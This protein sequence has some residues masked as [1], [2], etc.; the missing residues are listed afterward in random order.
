MEETIELRAVI[1][2]IFQGKLV[3]TA[4]TI[5]TMLLA[6]IVSWFV[7][8]E[9]YES[10]ATVQ[11]ISNT[12]ET[13]EVDILLNFVTAEFTPQVFMQRIKNENI[14]NKAFKEKSLENKYISKHL[15]A[16]NAPNTAIVEL[17]YTSN[18]AENAQKEL[19]VI[20]ESTK[21]Q[22][23]TSIQNTLQNLEKTYK[24]ETEA[25]GTE[26]EQ[27]INA[28]NTLIRANRLPNILILQTILSS[29]ITLNITEEQTKALAGVNG[30]MQHQLLQL[31]AQIQ[32]KSE[33]YRKLLINY[34]S[35]QTGL[36]S[37]T[38]DS[39]VR[40]IE[41]PT[42]TETPVTPNKWL[43]IAIGFVIGLMLGVGGVFFREYWKNSEQL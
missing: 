1:R 13:K 7:I 41:E 35:V 22:M 25:L 6:A 40:V 36:H 30:N 43:N 10:T 17:I 34:Q 19:Q 31:Q 8:P 32:A 14:I 38:I 29:D 15:T 18:S 21:V 33:E 37:F 16:I 28:Y 2:V 27:I 26:I 4:T 24:V 3:I 12:Q 42:I 23:N 20:V 5:V 9:K 39:F 11:V